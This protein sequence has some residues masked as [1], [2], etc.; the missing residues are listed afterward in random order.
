MNKNNDVVKFGTFLGVFTPSVLTIL[1]LVMY[2]RFGW[3][4]GNVGLAATLLIVLLATSITFATGLSASAIATNMRVGVGGEYYMISRSLGLELGGAIGIP[5]FLCRTLSITFYSFG[6]AE[7]IFSFFPNV[8]SQAVQILA[9]VIIVLVT[10]LSSKSASLALKLQIPIMVAV[11]VSIVAL[12]IGAIQSGFHVPEFTT[13]YKTT[14]GG[15]WYVFAIF[16]PAVTG[17]TA[18]IGMSGDLKDPQKSIPTGTLW[19]VISGSFIYVII[20]FVLSATNAL[21]IEQMSQP[22]IIWTKVAVLGAWLI[23]PGI[24]GAILSSAFGSV[25]AGPRVLQSLSNDG[26]APKIFSKL[27]KDGQPAIATYFCGAIAL[28]AVALGE[29]NTVAKFVSILFLTLYVMIN[30]SAV[31]E[32]LVGDPSYR[33]TINVHWMFSVF[34]SLGAIVVMFLISPVACIFAVVFE[35]LLYLY[36]RKKS[37]EKQWGDVRAG[38]WISLARYTLMRLNKH[39]N[40]SRNWRPH[41][42]IFV[43][44][45]EKKISLIKLASLFN[46][47][48]GIVSVNQIIQGDLMS[49]SFDVEGKLER[50]NDAVRQGGLFCFNEVNVVNDIE[51]GL[52]SIAQSKGLANLKSN[53]VMF[54]WSENREK[55]LSTL[56][57]AKGLANADISTVIAR[58]QNSELP[59][60]KNQ[61]DI[62][63]RGK[64]S[65][66]DLMLLM[67]HLLSLNPEWN[68]AKI[69]IRSIVDSEDKKIE[70]SRHLTEMIKETR[71]R[72]NA[73]VIVNND[74]G[75]V[76]KLMH[77]YSSSA[78]V[79]FI[80]LAVFGVDN[81]EDHVN[82]IDEL[83]DGF[84]SVVLVK[85]AGKFAGKLI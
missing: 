45:I 16:F 11:A 3:V 84:K 43:S 80:G 62:W 12:F 66:G 44:E 32:K 53:T 24:W 37:L 60:K 69:V 59:K 26:L 76:V 22:G 34:G 25:L 54:G 51:Q 67:A 79:V 41:F 77:E 57:V 68:K 61:V 82:H 58:L 64:H 63:W 33:P 29:L 6:I 52:L 18:G 1:G 36:I 56:R 73:E 23:Y 75:N 35:V 83:C 15:F 31:M 30:L 50:M 49:K 55:R 13:T 40:S 81:E 47:N 70:M 71:I 48:K 7:S 17:F 78:D 38:G 65:N 14:S 28:V 2:L 4:I 20:V 85:N 74:N 27:T 5:L 10:L 46:Q 39:K 21:S 19:A 9:A 8:G 42:L 72:A